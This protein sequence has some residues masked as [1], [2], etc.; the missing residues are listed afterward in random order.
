M[1]SRRTGRLRE[2]SPPRCIRRPASH[3]YLC[4]PHHPGPS[5]YTRPWK[6][7][8]RGLEDPHILPL[9]PERADADDGAR[10]ALDVLDLEELVLLSEGEEMREERVEVA[11]R[12]E[13]EDLFVVR[14]VEV[15][16]DAE[17]L[18]VDVLDRRGKVLREVPAWKCGRL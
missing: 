3:V 11:L 4:V 8:L 1:V 5:E 6:R 18:A 17:E 10:L 9:L 16:E 15:R 14:M 2:P 12:S 7:G 13:M